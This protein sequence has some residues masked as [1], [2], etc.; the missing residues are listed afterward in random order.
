LFGEIAIIAAG[1]WCLFATHA[2]GWESKYLG[3]AVGS[4][5]IRA[6]RMLLVVSP[7]MIGLGVIADAVHSG[8][9]VM[10]PWLS[11]RVSERSLT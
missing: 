2:G 9:T 5:G 7:P 1:N 10:Q 6:A 11:P 3:F 4:S 8:N